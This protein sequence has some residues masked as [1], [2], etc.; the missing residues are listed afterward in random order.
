MRISGQDRLH[1]MQLQA[2][3]TCRCASSPVNAAHLWHSGWFLCTCWFL[4][5]LLA[6]RPLL[7]SLVVLPS[8]S[9]A[10]CCSTTLLCTVLRC[11]GRLC[12]T[13]GPLRLQAACAAF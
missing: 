11:L 3:L 13:S 4:C 12:C 10:P 7:Q 5:S 8:S 6:L 1:C 2:S 9:R